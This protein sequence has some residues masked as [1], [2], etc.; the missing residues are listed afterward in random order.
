MENSALTIHVILKKLIEEKSRRDK[1][2]FTGGQLANALNMPRS[3]ITKLTHQ[4]Q[5][6]RVENPRIDTLLKIVE[7]FKADGFEITLDDLLGTKKIKVRVQNQ[8]V[9]AAGIKKTVPLFSLDEDLN[10]PF[11]SV[12]IKI[13]NEAHDIIALYAN[14]DIKPLFKKGSIFI[15]DLN[16]KLKND[17]L[18]AVKLAN[19]GKIKIQKYYEQEGKKI[20]TSIDSNEKFII[21]TPN[22]FCK[23]IGVVIQINANT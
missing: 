13:F 15:V 18:V 11:G 10:N 12:E 21:L 16:K 5:S 17:T 23:I 2:K 4:D 19:D 22:I 7:F 3:V 20:L 9:P 6:K 14:Q 1:I 8:K